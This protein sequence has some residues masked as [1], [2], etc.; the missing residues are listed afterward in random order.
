MCGYF[1]EGTEY[2]AFPDAFARVDEARV[3]EFLD[4]AVQPERAA[5]SVIRPRV[6]EEA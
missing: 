6:R 4:Q 2:Y 1:F 5:L 3:L